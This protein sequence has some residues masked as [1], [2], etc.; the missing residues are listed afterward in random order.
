MTVCV[1]IVFLH[2]F[3]FCFLE[4]AGQVLFGLNRRVYLRFSESIF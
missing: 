3:F 2:C 4:I 1:E